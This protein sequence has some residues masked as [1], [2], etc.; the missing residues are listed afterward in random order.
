MPTYDYR[1]KKCGHAFEEFQSI[2]AEPIETCPQCD[3]NVERLINGGVGLIFKGS[4]F[5]LTDY[6]RAKGPKD[7]N[8][9]DSK[10]DS[11][12]KADA[13]VATTGEKTAKKELSN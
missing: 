7:S 4:G 13:S 3:G 8:N 5:Y 2:V 6:A 1:C 9:K 10:K 12:K 11:T